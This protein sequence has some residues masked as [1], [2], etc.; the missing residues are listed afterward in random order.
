M[1]SYHG[2]IASIG[3]GKR[4]ARDYLFVDTDDVDF[5]ARLI[6]RHAWSCCRYQDG[7]RREANFL[8]ANWLG[9]DFDNGAI[10]LDQAQNIFCDSVHIIGTTRSHRKDKKGVVVD[11]F[12]VI[13]KLATTVEDLHTYRAT[14]AWYINKYDCD[15]SAKD[16]ARFFWP[17]QEIV[18]K[19]QDG[20]CQDVY[21]PPPEVA[22]EPV[23]FAA[24]ELS[25]FALY[26]IRNH[27]AV[28]SRRQ[29]CWKFAK[30][31]YRAGF[32][33]DQIY[34]A[35]LSSATY[36]NMTACPDLKEELTGIISCAEKSLKREARAND[37]RDAEDGRQA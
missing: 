32:D 29:A 37:R 26:F 16:A 25:A 15:Q 12:R 5:M 33:S 35:L 21:L 36:R 9:L 14:A 23:A 19:S 7:H 34:R 24:G 10:S 4:Y 20:Y 11:R 30:D 6:S 28:G 27:V 1:I 22:Y 3:D 31:L 18:S 2:N 17:C 13:L 8:G